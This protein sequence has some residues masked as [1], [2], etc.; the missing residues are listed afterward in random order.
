[1][2]LTKEQIAVRQKE[3][4][5]KIAS[6]I[7]DRVEPHMAKTAEVYEAMTKAQEEFV[8]KMAAWEDSMAK[9]NVGLPGSE[10]AA[11]SG[12]FYFGRF[13]NALKMGN[14]EQHAPAEYDYIKEMHKV[15]G[16]EAELKELDRMLKTQT[17]GSDAAGGY[18]I[19][20]QIAA[21]LIDTLRDMPL[22]SQLGATMIPN[23]TGN[24]YRLPTQTGNATVDMYAEGGAPTASTLAFGQKNMTPHRAKALVRISNDVEMLSNPAIEGI[25]KADIAKGLSLNID[26][27]AWR[28][29]GSSNEPTGLINIGSGL[30]TS[31][32][33]NGAVTMALLHTFAAAIE[34]DLALKQGGKFAFCFNPRTIDVVRQLTNSVTGDYFFRPDAWDVQKP[35]IL[36]Y[37]FFTS[38]L[39]PKNVTVG[40]T[41]DLAEI[42]FG[43][44]SEMVIGYWGGLEIKN[45]DQANLAGTASANILDE[46][47]I[48]AQM[49]FDVAV[50][51]PQAFCVT[52][53]CSS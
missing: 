50:R 43:D 29:S 37:P 30:N 24:P 52:T 17:M 34:Q 32:F 5:E 16:K 33:S 31:S 35:T 27:M 47:W 3:A 42:Y 18:L 12:E 48:Y 44:W 21:G 22:I 38:N 26:S 11:E 40:A 53:D 6:M 13:I 20:P 28:G 19:A 46:T 36:G 10:G 9:R 1:M 14:V 51:H 8:L 4:E 15:A 49:K 39:V 23:I 25:V 7:D 45:F 2:E 41:G